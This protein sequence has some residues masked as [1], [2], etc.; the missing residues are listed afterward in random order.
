MWM[1]AANH[2]T[3]HRDPK[4]GV[5]QRLK[6]LKEMEGEALGPVKA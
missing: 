1:L 6:E 4:G 5:R 2:C 3:V